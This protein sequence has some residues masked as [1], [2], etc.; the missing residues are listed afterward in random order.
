M[1]MTKSRALAFLR[2]HQ[3]LP[4]DEVVSGSDLDEL[5]CVRQFLMEHPDEEALP[6]LLGVFGDGSGFGVYQLIESAVAVYP[7]AT[8]VA[9]LKENLGL[10]TRS[11]RYWCAQ[12]ATSFP[13]EGLVPSLEKALETTERDTRYAAIVALEAIGS[14]AALSALRRWLPVERDQELRA[15]IGDVLS[16]S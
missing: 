5:D 11:V 10:G 12:L 9:A 15:V 3:P 1:E 7:V 6:L 4:A 14:D 16:H 2:K 13:D 8:V